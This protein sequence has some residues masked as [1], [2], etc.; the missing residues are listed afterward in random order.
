MTLLALLF[1]CGGSDP[2]VA[3]PA[4]AAKLPDVVIV[5]LD[6]TRADRLG[7]YGYA[8]GE[9]PTIDALAKRGR[10]YERAYSPLPLTIPSHATIFTGLYP[11]SLGIRDNGHGELEESQVTLAERLHDAGY[12]TAASVAAYVTTRTWGFSQGFDA[13]FDEIPE[14]KG[15]Y[16]HAYR[17]GEI[18]VDDALAWWSTQDGSKPRFLWVHLYDAH[19]PYTPVAP[20]KDLLADRPYDAEIA[21][22]DAQLQ[23]ILA[24]TDP[25]NTVVIVVGDHGEG[26]GDHGELTHGLFV[27]DST[28]HV[29][30]IMAGPEIEA[31]QRVDE[32]VSLADVTPTLLD[33]LGLPPQEKA[34]GVPVPSGKPRAIYMETFQLRDRYGLSPH[35]GVVQGDEKL[36][37]VPQPELYDVVDDGAE[38]SNLADRPG[39]A[40]RVAALEK[41]LD[42]FGFAPPGEID[43]SEHDPSVSAALEALGYVEGGFVGEITGDL[44]DPK[45]NKRLIGLSQRADRYEMEGRL[46][47][48]VELYATLIAEFPKVNEFRNR[49][50]AALG[51]LG[52]I[53]EALA[54]GE[55]ALRNDPTN[56]VLRSSVAGLLARSGKTREASILFQS[57]AADQPH[58]AKIKASAVAALLQTRDATAKQDALDL[59]TKYLAENPGDPELTG[60]VGIALVLLERAPEAVPYL[61]E[62]AKADPPPRDVC[63]RLAEIAKARG[64]VSRSVQLLE[65]ELANYPR[66]TPAAVMLV[67]ELSEREEWD[68]V[69]AISGQQLAYNPE[70]GLLWHTKAQ[71]LFNLGQYQEARW[72]L[73]QG[74]EVAPESSMMLLL[75][76]NLLAKEGKRE[77]GERRFAQAQAAF[78]RELATGEVR[79]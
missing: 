18:V 70:S 74:L 69:A 14:N 67:A 79:P 68:R 11:P 1:A 21:Y 37:R 71:A 60:L 29:P 66:N 35:V 20:W 6:T 46:E 5:T 27:Y 23:R 2:A 44:P 17:K 19:F 8:D 7:A 56:P 25:E 52:R 53:D 54:Q 16:W 65:Q 73:D 3:P 10:V 40:E 9:T 47:E 33:A 42:G 38:V 72:A 55:E 31:G 26:L 78:E 15:N 22:C 57:A 76:A 50:A 28:Q 62:A 24:A 41:A 32:P 64:D 34:D 39:S 45:D 12:T 30:W 48:A 49:R 75:D 4:P 61:E 43:A 36:I 13:Y 63:L 77:E 59:G 51:K 58:N